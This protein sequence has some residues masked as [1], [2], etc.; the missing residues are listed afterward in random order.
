MGRTQ[1]SN[2]VAGFVQPRYRLIAFSQPHRGNV[3]GHDQS[4]P[5]LTSERDCSVDCPPG[6]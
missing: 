2:W 5:R 1:P 4:E 6:N 3:I